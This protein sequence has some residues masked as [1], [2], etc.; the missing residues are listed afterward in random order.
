MS[1]IT[2]F[3]M[4]LVKGV[5]MMLVLLGL[6]LVMW[7][8]GQ[9]HIKTQIDAHFEEVCGEVPPY[10]KV[11]DGISAY[12]VEAWITEDCVSTNEPHL[13]IISNRGK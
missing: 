8:A 4:M 1:K 3:G 6:T 7:E 2:E 9:S 11:G 5:V 13:W 10:R 12:Y